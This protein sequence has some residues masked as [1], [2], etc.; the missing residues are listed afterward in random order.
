M[1]FRITG[2]TDPEMIPIL[3]ANE[4]NQITSMSESIFH[5]L[6]T[7]STSNRITSQS[8]NVLN[9]AALGYIQDL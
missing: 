2:D 5:R 8:K 1:T 9:P 3:L 7:L 4:S 6:P